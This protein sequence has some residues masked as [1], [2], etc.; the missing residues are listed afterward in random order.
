MT[1]KTTC[2]TLPAQLAAKL[3]S[4]RSEPPTVNDEIN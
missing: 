2:W 3:I 1:T 4:N